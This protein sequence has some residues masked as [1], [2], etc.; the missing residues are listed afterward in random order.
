MV[1]CMRQDCSGWKNGSLP[2]KAKRRRE[3]NNGG[4]CGMPAAVIQEIFRLRPMYGR[5]SVVG[6]ELLVG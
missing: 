3:W 1:E 4:D 2:A 6:L 5:L